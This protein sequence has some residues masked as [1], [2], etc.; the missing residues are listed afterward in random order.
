[1]Q[2]TIVVKIGSSSLTSDEG[3]LNRD[4]IAFFASELARL[5]REGNRVLLVTS[6]AVAAGFR[7]MGYT[8]RPKLL[9]EKQASASVGQ[10]LL[11]Q[12]YQAAFAEYGV[13]IGQILLTRSDF[14]NRRRIQNAQSTIEELLRRGILPVVNEND[15]VAVDELKF[16]DNDTLSALVANLVRARRLLILTDTDGLYTEDPRRNPEA[17]RI[18]RVT[19]IDE[20]IYRIAGGSGSMV[21]TGGMRS[22]IEAARIA[23]RGGVPCFVGRVTEPGD[24]LQAAGGTGRGTYFDTSEHNLPMKKQWLGF[25]SQPK[26]L[27]T[28]DE[29]AESALVSGGRSLLPAGVRE[30]AGEFHPG[31]VIEVAGVNGQ[32]IGRGSSTTNRG[33][34]RRWPASAPTKCSAASRCPASK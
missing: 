9:H 24:L 23:M 4:S 19:E 5:Q 15:T 21:G 22:K 31:D 33:S 27:V 10:A 34:C 30:V 32:I 11:M 20:H 2:G 29:G 6:G 1:M 17:K 12:A 7:A 18:D 13:G 26:G 8:V 3:G 14:S 25:H 28:V 16:G